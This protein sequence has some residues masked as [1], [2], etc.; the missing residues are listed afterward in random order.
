MILIIQ[1]R[2]RSNIGLVWLLAASPAACRLLG[3]LILR[4]VGHESTESL[5]NVLRINGRQVQRHCWC[6]QEF[7]GQ[8][9]EVFV[10]IGQFRAISHVFVQAN[11]TIIS[12]LIS[13]LD[14]RIAHDHATA[15]RT[16]NLAPLRGKMWV[17]AD[18]NGLNAGSLDSI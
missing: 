10:N 16:D 11:S 4:L 15:G 12:Y 6:R 18:N 5:P 8:D 7:P 14:K 2:Q 1:N 9:A 17:T 3:L 13:V